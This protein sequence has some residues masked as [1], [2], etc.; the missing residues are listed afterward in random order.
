MLEGDPV[1][2]GGRLDLLTRQVWLW[3]QC[4]GS[5]AGYRDMVQFNGT[6]EDCDRADRLGIA[7]EG[8]GAF[9]RFKDVPARWPGELD[10]WYG[11]ADDRQRGRAGRGWPKQATAQRGPLIHPL[12]DQWGRTASGRRRLISTVNDAV[13]SIEPDRTSAGPCG[14]GLPLFSRRR[15]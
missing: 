5:R 12:D 6:V 15:R 11:Y 10:R 3:V 2:G 14:L 13:S 8:R 9:R 7:L 4:E 1:F